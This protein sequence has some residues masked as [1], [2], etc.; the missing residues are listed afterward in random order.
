MRKKYIAESVSEAL[1]R[2]KAELGEGA[3]IL[4]AKNV[5][6]RGF[7]GY[8]A[9]VLV[10]VT[11]S[12][13]ARDLAA[14]EKGRQTSRRRR[15]LRYLESLYAGARADGAPEDVEDQMRTLSGLLS[16]L[17]EE[18][19]LGPV[20]HLGSGPR[21]LYRRLIEAC[22]QRDLALGLVEAVAARTGSNA[23]RDGRR[24]EHLG[25]FLA[26]AAGERISFT[27]GLL[28]PAEGSRTVM[29]IGPTGV[30]KTTTI[31]KLAAEFQVARGL[32]VSLVTID[33]YRVAAADQ[34]ERYAAIMGIPLHVVSTPDELRHTLRRF[35]GGL[36]FIDTA[37]RSHRDELKMGDLAE[38][39]EVARPDEVHLVLAASSAYANLFDVYGRFEKLGVGALLFTKLDEAPRCGAVF[40]LAA[41]SGMPISYLTTGQ[42][43]PEDIEVATLHGILDRMGSADED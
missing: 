30:G 2:I 25:E 13:E 8:R 41:V 24:S 28:P 27:G 12:N 14:V 29:L 20:A 3:V 11:A 16:D 21:D 34:L 37:G 15:S 31:A 38:F 42:E 7:L 4:E 17:V 43:V 23:S 26:Q 22:V 33:T 1:A 35:N 5:E 6:A 19:E 40:S 18:T 36:V 32:P 10:E 39:I 9:R